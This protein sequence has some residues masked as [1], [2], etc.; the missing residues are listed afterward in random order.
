MCRCSVF[1]CLCTD[2]CSIAQCSC[3]LK[4]ASQAETCCP[5]TCA[6][7]NPDVLLLLPLLLRCAGRSSSTCCAPAPTTCPRHWH[8]L[9]WSSW[10]SA[11]S[12]GRVRGVLCGGRAGG[13]RLA[14]GPC[15]P[16]PPTSGIQRRACEPLAELLAQEHPFQLVCVSELRMCPLA[17]VFVLSGVAANQLAG[18]AVVLS[19]L[20]AGTAALLSALCYAEM[21]VSLPVAGGAFNYISISFGE[22]AAW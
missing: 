15:D 7:P 12:L 1:A 20:L 13:W 3:L 16:T 4:A 6:C 9:T 17:G 18:P 21:A 8:W 2:G 14:L 22:M 19:Y 10:A 11:A 5:A